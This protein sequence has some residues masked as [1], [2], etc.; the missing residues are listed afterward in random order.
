MTSQSTVQSTVLPNPQLE[1]LNGE[2]KRIAV[3]GNLKRE[4]VKEVCGEIIQAAHEW[5]IEVVLREQMIKHLELDDK[6]ADVHRGHLDECEL[7]VTLG[8]DGTLLHTARA[9][10][11]LDVPLLA[12]NMG[13][14]GFN[15]QASRHNHL[16]MLAKTVQG[17]APIQERMLLETTLIQDGEELIKTTALN[18]LVVSKKTESRVVHLDCTIDGEFACRYSGDGLLVSTP[19]GSTAYNLATGGPLIHPS[20]AVY[21]LT[22]I[23]S[24]RNG[25]QPLVIPAE[26]Q[27]EFTWQAQKDREQVVICIDGQELHNF[28]ENAKLRIDRAAHPLRLVQNENLHYFERLNQ[29]IGWGGLPA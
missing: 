14:L 15:T 21:S 11:P 29:K 3:V 5:E 25:V 8:G 19:T 2:I 17:K 26:S 24:T 9:F 23:C 1:G 22:A 12:V 10:Y 16:E 6:E 7:I 13:N 28:P 18:D 20:L 27:L 4:G